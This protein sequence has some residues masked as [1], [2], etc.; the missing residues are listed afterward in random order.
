MVIPL[1]YQNVVI[2]AVQ[3]NI[4]HFLKEDCKDVFI[5]LDTHILVNP[6][7][8]SRELFFLIKEVASILHKKYNI[9]PPLRGENLSVFPLNRVSEI[10]STENDANTILQSSGLFEIDRNATSPFGIVTFG[11]ML[12]CFTR[13]KDGSLSMWIAQR[14]LKK[15][16]HQYP[17][18]LDPIIGGAVEAGVSPRQA[19]I[20]EAWEECSMPKYLAE[21]AV[22]KGFVSYLMRQYG[23]IKF[24]ILFCYDLDLSRTEMP[25]WKPQFNDNSI[26]NF[27]LLSAQEVA[28]R[29]R[30]TDDFKGGSNLIKIDFLIRNNIIQ[31]NEI[32][33]EKIKKSLRNLLLPFHESSQQFK[34]VSAAEI[35]EINF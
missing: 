27:F 19:L 24:Q 20:K 22:Y 14:S 31:K 2:G 30:Y 9:I 12:N 11:V 13:S 7:I 4:L 34:I 32:F 35:Q 25:F 18:K 3:K 16:I 33:Y 5:V 28:D 10:L 21:K 29:L 1:Y 23:G 15:P 26:E 6:N 8:G 17:G